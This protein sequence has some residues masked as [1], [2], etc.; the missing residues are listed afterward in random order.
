[1]KNL[2]KVLKKLFKN[3]HVSKDIIQLDLIEKMILESIVERKFNKKLNVE[4]VSIP[5]L[6]D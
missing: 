4:K 1:M 3:E 6:N 5:E 2:E